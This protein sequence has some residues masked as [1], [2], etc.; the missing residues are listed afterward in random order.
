MGPWIEIYVYVKE[1]H[2]PPRERPMVVL[3]PGQL[4]HTSALR[5]PDGTSCAEGMLLNPTPYAIERFGVSSR[6]VFSRP[7]KWIRVTCSAG[8]VPKPSAIQ[9]GCVGLIAT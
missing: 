4:T 7:V 6:T 3:V 5:G 8:S 1:A 9:N 2:G